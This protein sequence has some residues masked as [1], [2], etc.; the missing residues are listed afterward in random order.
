V[1]ERKST[2]RYAYYPGC[3]SQAITKEAS[4]TTRK[5]ADVLGIELK[6]MPGA[7]CCGAGLLTD[8]DYDLYIALNARIFSQ[9]EAMGM[10]IMT[11]CSTCLMV[12][13][14][15]NRDLKADPGLME[16][17]NS[18]LKKVGLKYNGSIGIKLLSWV[19]VEDYG[20]EN[21]KKKVIRSLNGLKVAPFYGCHSLRPSDVLG[22]DDPEKPW[23]LEAIIDVLGGEA[24][25][26]EA[27]TKCCGFQ[28]DLV[29]EDTAVEMTGK[30]LLDAKDEGGVCMVTPCP[31]CHIN[32]DSY[33]SMAEKKVNRK[34]SMPVFHLAQ[35]VGLALGMGAGE[36]ELSRHIVSAEDV[37]YEAGIIK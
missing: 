8:S 36:L 30:R 37:L 26:Y 11:I 2:L 31:F 25:E 17:T 3:T 13:S 10:D 22:F 32:L 21:L 18:I 4:E 23:S 19:L 5:V 24:I 34:I 27:K 29:A 33:Q 35:L 16:R 28:V 7:N 15:A 12:M 20:L 9:A 1:G 14:T 6:D